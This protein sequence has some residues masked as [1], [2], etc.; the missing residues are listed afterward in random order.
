MLYL[1]FFLPLIPLISSNNIKP[2]INLAPKSAN[3]YLKSKSTDDD[4][5]NVYT[6]KPISTEVILNLDLEVI[7]RLQ[8]L[9]VLATEGHGALGRLEAHPFHGLDQGFGFPVRSG[10][11][12]LDDCHGRGQ[13]RAYGEWF[14][15]SFSAF[16]RDS[17]ATRRRLISKRS[18]A[19][20]AAAAKGRKRRQ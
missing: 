9:M 5:E 2:D 16:E 15:L 1:R 12:R 3:S 20:A 19:G 6:S 8:C 17:T 7:H 18:P 13:L 10:F 14:Q 4:L 11:E